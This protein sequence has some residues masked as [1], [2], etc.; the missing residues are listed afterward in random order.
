[1]ALRNS[2][3]QRLTLPR[4]KA[5][6]S[7]LAWFP[8]ISFRWCPPSA[9]ARPHQNARAAPSGRAIRQRRRTNPPPPRRPRDYSIAAVGRA[10]DLLEAL[11]ADRAGSAGHPGRRRAMHPHRRLPP[12]A[13]AAGTRFRHPGRGARHLAAGRALGACLAVPRRARCAGGH[14][15][16]VPR[17]TRQGERRERLP[18]HPRRPGE[19]DDRDLPGRPWP[20]RL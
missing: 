1:M 19:R 9:Q 20:A 13:H 15:D 5:S 14:R 2:Y 10:L 16:A 17:R 4:A 3:Q 6:R 8:T 7:V 18:A 11:A 12:A